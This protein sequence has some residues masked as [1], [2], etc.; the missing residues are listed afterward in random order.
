MCPGD[1][2]EKSVDLHEV[3]KN[4]ARAAE[5]SVTNNPEI[6]IHNN[7]IILVENF[8]LV[9]SFVVIDRVTGIL[10]KHNLLMGST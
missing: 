10:Q 7:V 5:I 6:Y 2:A 3:V 8:R 1:S 9:T 4:S